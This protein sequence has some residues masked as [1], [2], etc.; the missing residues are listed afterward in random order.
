MTNVYIEVDGV[1]QIVA[2]DEVVLHKACALNYVSK[3]QHAEAQY[4]LCEKPYFSW[5]EKIYAMVQATPVTHEQDGFGDSAI[6]HLHYY[7]GDNHWYITERDISGDSEQYQAFG[8]ACLAA[9]AGCE[10]YGYISIVELLENNVLLDLEFK[11]TSMEIIKQQ[12]KGH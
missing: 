11:P 6:A 1:Q 7:L 5:V 4:R 8:Y 3:E 12:F 9:F 10:E 2:L